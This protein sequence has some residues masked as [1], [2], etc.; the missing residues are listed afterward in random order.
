MPSVAQQMSVQERR[1]QMLYGLRRT[2]ADTVV[3]D[4]SHLIHATD[5]D[6][7]EN[8]VE[9]LAES[10]ELVRSAYSSRERLVRHGYA[11]VNRALAVEAIERKIVATNKAA[12][13][14]VIKPS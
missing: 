7:A 14:R 8:L 11:V 5:M 2:Q 3:V 6:T 12:I 9:E 1:E 10:Q 13:D 4:V